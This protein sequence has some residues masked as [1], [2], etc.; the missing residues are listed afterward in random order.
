MWRN[1]ITTL[2]LSVFLLFMAVSCYFLKRK[3]ALIS[4]NNE[5]ISKE[6]GY[7]NEDISQILENGKLMIQSEYSAIDPL[8]LLITTRNDTICLKDLVTK[9]GKL[10]LFY[11]EQYCDLCFKNL[12]QHVNDYIANTGTQNL[13][14]IAKY[15]NQR[16]FNYFIKH[17]DI[18]AEIYLSHNEL[19][20]SG[21]QPFFF[22]LDNSFLAKYVNVPNKKYLNNIDLYLRTV[23]E[24]ITKKN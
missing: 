11:N 24:Y 2:V 4:F 1:N 22:M 8:T 20:F 14:L 21:N 3:V 17:N 6:V 19:D 7:L 23:D 5:T 18:K 12:L 16:A 9:K 10:I 13:I 15:E